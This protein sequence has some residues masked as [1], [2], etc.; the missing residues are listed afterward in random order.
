MSDKKNTLPIR[1]N[2]LCNTCGAKW[3]YCPHYDG[4][5]LKR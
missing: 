5:G 4:K 1:N 3:G 2:G